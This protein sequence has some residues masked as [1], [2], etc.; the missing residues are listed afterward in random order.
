[1]KNI[2][3][4][5]RFIKESQQEVES[6][7]NP[8][9]PDEYDINYN[10]G[11]WSL[12]LNFDIKQ[13]KDQ[14]SPFVYPSYEYTT[15]DDGEGFEILKNFADS[16]N[17]FSKKDIKF[18]NGRQTFFEEDNQLVSCGTNNLT[19][20]EIPKE[21]WEYVGQTYIDDDTNPIKK[22]AYDITKEIPKL[23]ENK[24][25]CP[26]WFQT[27]DIDPK[28]NN[29]YRFT[30]LIDVTQQVKDF[31]SATEEKFGKK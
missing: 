15:S 22:N 25:Y 3:N 1:M 29:F 10:S 19:M 8:Q 30:G 2:K 9:V 26:F 16:I 27:E 12:R 21:V 28:T 6:K 20:R 5:L 14:G 17:E 23:E 13:L 18:K 7:E 11:A 31:I 4:Y 24:I